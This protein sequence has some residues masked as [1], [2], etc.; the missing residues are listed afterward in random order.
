MAWWFFLVFLIMT[1]FF[2]F[3]FKIQVR[4]LLTKL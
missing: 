4:V 1:I 2:L 3:L